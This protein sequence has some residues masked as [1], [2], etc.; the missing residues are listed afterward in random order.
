MT[1][2]D[3]TS[4][5]DKVARKALQLARQKSAGYLPGWSGPDE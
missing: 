3:L 5:F 1:A 4:D 2:C